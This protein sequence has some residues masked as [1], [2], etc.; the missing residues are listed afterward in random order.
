MPLNEEW[1]TKSW[2]IFTVEYY[3]TVK[4]NEI[5]EFAGKLDETGKVIA[6]I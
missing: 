4:K 5:V 6:Q 2:F 1:I 3:L